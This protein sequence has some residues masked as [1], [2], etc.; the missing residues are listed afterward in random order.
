ML[1]L[2]HPAWL[3]LKKFEKH[4]LPPIDDNLQAMFDAEHEFNSYLT[5]FGG[6]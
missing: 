3:W 4:R 6:S 5:L 2:D 1:F